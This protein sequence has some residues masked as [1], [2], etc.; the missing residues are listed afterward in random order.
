VVFAATVLIDMV[1]FNTM[2][3]WDGRVSAGDYQFE[4]GGKT[5]QARHEFWPDSKLKRSTI[6]VLDKDQKLLQTVVLTETA[7]GEIEV[8]VDGKLRGRVHGISEIP[9]ASIYGK[10]SR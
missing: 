2:D 9:V 5:Y 3:F 4:D 7:K 8:I 10:D 1:I 6:R